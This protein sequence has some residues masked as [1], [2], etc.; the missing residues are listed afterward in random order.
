M[1]DRYTNTR[2]FPPATEAR[3]A[4]RWLEGTPAEVE[5]RETAPGAWSG[6]RRDGVSE[7]CAMHRATRGRCPGRDRNRRVPKRYPCPP[8]RQ[9]WSVAGVA[10]L[11]RNRMRQSRTSGSVGALE[12]L[13]GLSGGPPSCPSARG[14]RWHVTR[15]FAPRARRRGAQGDVADSYCVGAGFLGGGSSFSIRSRTSGARHFTEPM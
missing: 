12:Q 1:F 6:P 13:P 11:P 2:R 3:R 7:A 8:P 9:R 5:S 4:L 10:S 14:I 15:P